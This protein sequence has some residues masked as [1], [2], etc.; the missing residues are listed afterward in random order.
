MLLS[1]ALQVTER[2]LQ[3]WPNGGKDA[4]DG[5][6]GGVAAVLC[7]YPR[8]VSTRCADPRNGV[9][10]ECKFL[11]TIAELVAWCD[12]ETERI[13]WPID[14]EDRISRD[15]AAFKA[16]I[17]RAQQEE[18]RRKARPTLDELRAKYGPNWGLGG[19]KKDRGPSVEQTRQ[20]I[21]AQIGQA[22]FDAIPNQGEEG[23]RTLGE[24]AAKA[25]AVAEAQG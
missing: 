22:A 9:A 15:R 2:L 7:D 5:Y 13:R 16:S 21:I 1:E 19:W 4:G 11:P 3:L 17:E 20:E 8:M 25:R 10:R 14:L 12:K 23:W 24:V 6:I 18:A